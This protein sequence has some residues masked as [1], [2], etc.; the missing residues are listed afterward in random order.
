MEEEVVVVV[1]VVEVVDCVGCKP[2]CLSFQGE[3]SL[4]VI[5]RQNKIK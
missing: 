1:V 4:A 3:G 5:N 2:P